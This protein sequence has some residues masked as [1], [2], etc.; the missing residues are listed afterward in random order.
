MATLTQSTAQPRQAA[1]DDLPRA[2]N[3]NLS[4]LLGTAQAAFKDLS[5]SSSDSDAHGH[6]TLSQGDPSASP[7]KR[8]YKSPRSISRDL[9]RI[10]RTELASSRSGTPYASS[11]P[12]RRSSETTRGRRPRE[13]SKQQLMEKLVETQYLPSLKELVPTTKQARA[14]KYQRSNRGAR[15]TPLK[16]TQRVYISP[17]ELE[18]EGF[19][20]ISRESVPK[21]NTET[22][23]DQKLPTI[24]TTIAPHLH[25]QT[26]A[27]PQQTIPSSSGPSSAAAATAGAIPPSPASTSQTATEEIAKKLV[28]FKAYSAQDCHFRDARAVSTAS[29]DGTPA[30]R[31]TVGAGVVAQPIPRP[32]SQLRFTR[33]KEDKFS[34]PYAPTVPQTPRWLTAPRAWP[35]LYTPAT[36][37]PEGPTAGGHLL[38]LPATLPAAHPIAVPHATAAADLELLLSYSDPPTCTDQPLLRGQIV[39]P[40]PTVAP[41]LPVYTP[42]HSPVPV[43]AILSP[44]SRPPTLSTTKAFCQPPLPLR[45]IASLQQKGHS[46]PSP[47]PDSTKIHQ[48]VESPMMGPTGSALGPLPLNAPEELDVSLLLIHYEGTP[49]TLDF[50][51]HEVTDVP[52]QHTMRPTASLE[53]LLGL[54]FL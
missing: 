21:L 6:V 38:P 46:Q 40:V 34:H 12:A 20:T 22:K 36:A 18:R 17:E 43:P 49:A 51:P 10:A 39:K 13:L 28:P 31:P 27:S 48:F 7:E 9:R 50:T 19:K 52:L 45:N 3:Q 44:S 30:P 23:N 25:L 37:T 41:A 15:P 33:A 26:V 35:Q 24:G 14:V 54:V 5:I 8:T 42:L 1:A 16:S 29:V 47:E 53:D 11:G 32:P 2:T 4:E